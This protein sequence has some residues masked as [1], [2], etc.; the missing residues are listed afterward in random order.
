VLAAQETPETRP[1][2]GAS[3][4]ALM[5]LPAYFGNVARGAVVDEGALNAAL[6][7]GALV[8]AALDVAS[9]EPLPPQD[10]MWKFDDVLITPYLSAVN[11]HL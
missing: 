7:Q 1:M 5:K 11:E 10:K 9:E 4:F 3:D 2:R 8:G 6:K